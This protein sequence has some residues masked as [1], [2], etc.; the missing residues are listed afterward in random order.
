MNKYLLTI[1]VC[2]MIAIIT[3]P[4]KTQINEQKIKNK[5]ES[6]I[7]QM[8]LE[9]KISLLHGKTNFKNSGVERLGIPCLSMSDGPHGVREDLNDVGWGEA[10]RTDDSSTYLPHLTSLASSWNPEIAY[11]FGTVIAEEAK[12]RNKNVM[13]GPGINIQRTPLGGRN[14]EYMSED[15]YL[16]SK[17]VVPLVKGIQ[18]NGTISCIKHFA[19]NNQEQD[20]LT[21]D[22]NIDERTLREIYLPAFEAAVT[23][24][25]ALAVMGAYNKFRGVHCCHNDYLL[26]KILKNEWDFKGIVISDW[27]GTHNT[28]EAANNGLDIEMGT[29]GPC[30]NNFMAKPLFE[31]VKNGNI[32]DSLIDEKVRRILYVTFLSKEQ[33]DKAK[34]SINTKE[35]RQTALKV[36]EEGIVLLKNTNHF[37]P[38]DCTKIKSIAIIGDN[39]DAKH[40]HTGG[41][42]MI[43]T[44]FE[45]TP[46]EGLEEKLKGKVL[47]NYAKGYSKDSIQ[48]EGLFNEA[49]ETAK[50]SDIVLFIG[51]LNHDF[52][53]EGHDKP[54]MLLPY[55]QDKLI[56]AIRK[57]NQKIAVILV[58]GSPVDMSKWINDVRCVIYSWYNGMMGGKALAS[59]LLGEINPSGKMP[60]TLPK[61]LEDSPEQVMGDYPGKNNFEE[62]K[63][64]ILVGYR[65][66]D[67]KNIEPQFCFG[68]GL[69]Y[70]AFT[71]SDMK[72]KI[73][74]QSGIPLITV[75]V[76]V[77]NT[78]SIEGKEVVQLYIKDEKCSLPRPEKELKAFKKI[79]LKPEQEETVTF[80]L[81]EKAL[82]FFNPDKNIWEYEKG[83]FTVLIG[84]SSRDIRL[85]K[86]I[87]I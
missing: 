24:G 19:V 59:M 37:L 56:N 70:S 41:S 49:I 78:S 40:A 52:D 16:V 48:N 86:T 45:I 55:N 1:L 63:E 83:D 47:I 53:D 51:G 9:E 13:L 64:G 4:S 8:T 75:T 44:P 26:K 36:A 43:K 54:N 46:L 61:K 31:E 11:E 14:F 20:R 69:S 17:L 29:D 3:N 72:T 39:A 21:V 60:F 15:P 76:K 27:G 85:K 58:C 2:L 65:W 80:E 28:P 57:V 77:K 71:Y 67:T 87:K 10:G 23:E 50:K 25:N 81:D 82:S 32:K 6:L 62:Y 22:V 42:S 7:K 34:G 12:A 35:H 18:S 38:L 30:E 66:Y 74:F 5:I 68:H 73:N 33:T 79:D 84:S